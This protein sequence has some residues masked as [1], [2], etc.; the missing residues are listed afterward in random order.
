MAAHPAPTRATARLLRASP[1]YLFYLRLLWAIRTLFMFAVAAIPLLTLSTT[2]FRGI[3]NAEV[4]KQ[5]IAALQAVLEE[6]K[7]LRRPVS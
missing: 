1:K 4:H 2:Y 7:A 6:A 5:L 3:D